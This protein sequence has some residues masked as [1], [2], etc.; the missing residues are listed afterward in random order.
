MEDLR[1]NVEYEYQELLSG[2]RTR[3]G[4]RT[5]GDTKEEKRHYTLMLVDDYLG[6]TGKMSQEEF[7]ERLKELKLYQAVKKNVYLDSLSGARKIRSLKFIKNVLDR[8]L[9]IETDVI[10]CYQVAIAVS[11]GETRKELI[12]EKEKIEALVRERST[13]NEEK[14]G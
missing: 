12:E 3:F 7:E 13:K 11:K 6:E 2:K 8:H 4:S 1:N 9:K 14:R 10:E 5:L